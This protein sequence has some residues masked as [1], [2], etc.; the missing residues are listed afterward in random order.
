MQ[1]YLKSSLK[2]GHIIC[3]SEGNAEGGRNEF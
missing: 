1:N 3:I 2:T